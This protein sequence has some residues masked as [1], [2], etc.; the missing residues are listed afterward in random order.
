MLK[1]FWAE[2]GEFE[3]CGIYDENLCGEF[4]FVEKPFTASRV[5][6]LNNA[7]VYE[8][9]FVNFGKDGIEISQLGAI[10]DFKENESF[11]QNSKFTATADTYKIT[12]QK[13]VEEV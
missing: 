8:I 9:Y 11:F 1:A 5:F 4:G 13:A 10:F 6:S 7:S 3:L 12:A 2:F